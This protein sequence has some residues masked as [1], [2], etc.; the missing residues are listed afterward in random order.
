MPNLKFGVF[1]LISLWFSKILVWFS[2][3]FK[4]GVLSS[5]SCVLVSLQSVLEFSLC[6]D[7]KIFKFGVPWCFPSKIFENKEH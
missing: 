4:F 7:L 2:K 1:L 6:L 3:N 5:C